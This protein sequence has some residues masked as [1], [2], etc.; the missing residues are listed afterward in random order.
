MSVA[1]MSGKPRPLKLV[2]NLADDGT[3]Q[4]LRGGLSILGFGLLAVV[5]LFTVLGGVGADGARNNAGWLALVIGMMCVP[6]GLMLSMLG[7]AKWLRRRNLR[8]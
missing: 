7:V 5:L 3:S 2:P 6:F 4:L 1:H 8:R